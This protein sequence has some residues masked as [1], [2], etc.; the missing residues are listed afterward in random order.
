MNDGST[1]QL[2]DVESNDKQSDDSCDSSY[3]CTKVDSRPPTP[4][5]P[6]EKTPSSPSNPNRR[7][8]AKPGFW[9]RRRSR[10]YEKG[11]H[12]SGYSPNRTRRIEVS[13]AE[14]QDAQE[15]AADIL[16]S[17]INSPTV[18][19]IM[20]LQATRMHVLEWRAVKEVVEGD[21]RARV[22]LAR[23]GRL[24]EDRRLEEVD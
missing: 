20:E 22:D 2:G 14:Q 5:R 18:R 15:L 7:A 4:A 6:S 9:S 13:A 21:R 16:G 11:L 24:L 8:K 19:I 10:D 23:L 17:G 12:K 3:D 1:L